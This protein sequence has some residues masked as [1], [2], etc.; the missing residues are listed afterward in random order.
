MVCILFGLGE[1]EGDSS[2][3]AVHSPGNTAPGEKKRGGRFDKTARFNFACQLLEALAGRIFGLDPSIH[4][5][6]LELGL[7]MSVV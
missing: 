5:S 1:Y 6:S 7:V 3:S 2:V 4:F